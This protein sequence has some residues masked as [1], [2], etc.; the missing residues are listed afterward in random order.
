MA[1]VDDNRATTII[2]ACRSARRLEE[3]LAMPSDAAARRL[4]AIPGIG[5]WTAA[6]TMQR[7]HGDADA[8]SIGDLHIPASVGLMLTG[9]AVDDEGMLALLEPYRGHRY[10]VTRLAEL[11]GIRR[12]R[13]APRARLRP[14]PRRR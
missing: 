4:R 6:E 2:R 13:R 1:G 7:A 11:S 5:P 3:T 14:L 8:V 9:R 10:R 12:Q